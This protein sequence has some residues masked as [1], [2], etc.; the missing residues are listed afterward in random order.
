M[1]RIAFLAIAL[2]LVMARPG[3]AFPQAREPRGFAELRSLV[4]EWQG[5]NE[6]G[7]AVDA[8]FK[9]VAGNSALLEVDTF[10]DESTNVIVYYMDTSRVALTLFSKANNQP[11]MSADPAVGDARKLDFSFVG[12]TN[13]HSNQ[14][15]H[16]HHLLLHFEDND[17][18]SAVWTW[19]HYDQEQNE[20]YRFTRKHT[21]SPRVSTS[22]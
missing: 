5:T 8:T 17:H 15:G 16:M 11:R 1:N 13:L 6:K 12:A 4:G 10:A 18:F 14:I 22:H 9:L 7:E 2:L 3:Y 20:T 21:D 19:R